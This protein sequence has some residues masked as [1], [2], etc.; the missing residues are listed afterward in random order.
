MAEKPKEEK[1]RG[2]ERSELAPWR[3]FGDLERWPN[4][5][6]N[7]PST[8]RLLGDDLFPWPW[9]RR[10]GAVVPALDVRE[11][12]QHYAVTVELPGVRREDVHV[13][14]EGGVLTIRGEKTSEREEK[15]EHRRY[16]ERSY[17]SFSRSF[18]LPPDADA[19]RLDASFKDGVLS[20]TI[21]R[22]EQAKPRTIAI[23]S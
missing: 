3:P 1:G 14:L 17:G 11:N 6:A 8:S 12:D 5:L 18:S 15:K 16:T 10:T 21:P 9:A 22:I 4:L 13:E 20:L 2:P 7:W 23:K 19:D